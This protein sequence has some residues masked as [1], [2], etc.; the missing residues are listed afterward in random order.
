MYKTQPLYDSLKVSLSDGIIFGGARKINSHVY[1]TRVTVTS[2]DEFAQNAIILANYNRLGE[3]YA[4]HVFR[5]PRNPKEE[6]KLWEAAAASAAAPPYFRAF[7]HPKTNREY[8]GGAFYNNNPARVAYRESR[9]LWHDV[10][11][12]PPDILVS[13]G[14][15]KEGHTGQKAEIKMNRGLVEADTQKKRG[16][17]QLAV[18]AP[19]TDGAIERRTIPL[20]VG[21]HSPEARS[22]I[23]DSNRKDDPSGTEKY[24]FIPLPKRL[25]RTWDALVCF[26]LRYF[27]HTLS[28]NDIRQVG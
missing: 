21:S 3:D 16:L 18:R 17:L 6:L 1:D 25:V 23:G 13:V 8:L 20:K 7:W 19:T 10:S 14:T 26:H 9:L 24:I 2:T 15:G 27:F 28:L 11:R 22:K 12:L 5:R 4:R